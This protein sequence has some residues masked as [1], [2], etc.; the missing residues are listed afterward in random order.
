MWNWWNGV[1][2]GNTPYFV[3]LSK[4]NILKRCLEEDFHLLKWDKPFSLK[5]D[6]IE[7]TNVVAEIQIVDGEWI[8]HNKAHVITLQDFLDLKN[9]ILTRINFGK[10]H[11]YILD[12]RIRLVT[13]EP[14]DAFMMCSCN[15]GL[16]E[17]LT[18]FTVL[19]DHESR[20]NQ[21]IAVSLETKEILFLG[22]RIDL[23]SCFHL[24]QEIVR[25]P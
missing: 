23:C 18:D 15:L 10:V 20:S 11:T 22:P 17:D 21:V 24:I 12:N 2:S 6:F 7:P 1:V 4:A 9:E 25:C 13:T 16:Y 3:N 8:H 5:P 14:Y 19:C